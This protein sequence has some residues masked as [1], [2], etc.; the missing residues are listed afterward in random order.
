MRQ[1]WCV[2]ADLFSCHAIWG[3]GGGSCREI[4]RCSLFRGFVWMG[5]EGEAGS[6]VGWVWSPR[7]RGL[8]ARGASA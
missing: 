5:G 3:G 4:R 1:L 6:Q 2:R 8:H 7:Y